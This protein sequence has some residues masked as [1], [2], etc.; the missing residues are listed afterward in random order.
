[1]PKLTRLQIVQKVLSAIDSDNVTATDET[2]ESEQV[3]ELLDTVYNKTLGTYPW[4]HLFTLDNL[5]TTSTAH[6]MRIPLDIQGVEWIRYNDSDPIYRTP[7]EMV[8]LLASRDTTQSDVD[9]NG[10]K[11][12][13]DPSYWTSNDDEFIIFDSYNGNLVSSLSKIYVV[14]EP[15]IMT[16]DDD[17]PDLPSRFHPI[18]VDGVIE[19]AFRT[20]VGDNQTAHIYARKFIQGKAQMKRWAR[21]LN[22][23]NSTYNDK[24]DYGRKNFSGNSTN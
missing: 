5:E 8:E 4:P 20:L 3:L 21:I 1:M 19:E 15:S 2:V 16:D 6:K 17:Y 7:F 24:V 11:N 14:K 23:D 13:K 22:F 9:S 18:L 12:A 10:A